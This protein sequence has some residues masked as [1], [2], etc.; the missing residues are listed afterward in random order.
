MTLALLLLLSLPWAR[1]TIDNSSKGADGVRLFDVNKDGRL[2]IVTGWEEGGEIRVCYQP[3]LANVK[4]PWPCEKV[5]AVG[6]PEDAVAFDMD[7]DGR[8]DVVSASEGTT[9]AIHFHWRSKD[10]KWTTE[11]LPAAAGKAQWMFT[12]PVQLDGRNGPDLIAGAKNEGA[13]LGWFEAPAKARNLAGWKWHP[14]RKAGWMM[15]IQA[16]DMDGD[17]DLDILFSDRKGE[18][19]GV[20]WLKNLGRARQW[21]EHYIG[22]R[23]FEVMFLTT[24]DMNG[25]GIPEVLTAAK[26]REV[27]IHYR[28]DPKG[29]KWVTGVVG[30]PGG[31]TAKAVR[32]AD[33]DGDGVA[34]LVVTHEQAAGEKS[35]VWV[36]KKSGERWE[37]IDIGG[38][39]GVKY[40][41]IELQDVDGDGDLD[42]VTCEE[43][44]NLGVVWYENP[45]KR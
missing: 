1:H 38:A 30:W 42:V 41:L 5:G 39:E 19:K 12:V 14:L 32:V 27:L 8:V 33:L 40:D 25:D 37:A 13:E 45:A 2:D 31:G 16:L 21:R 28:K 9:R 24:A 17:G 44:D 35:G 4:E 3:V 18:R 43:S 34:E 11:A 26:P 10:G 36:L 15:S 6:N 23:D 22:G 29:E 20:Y 7:R